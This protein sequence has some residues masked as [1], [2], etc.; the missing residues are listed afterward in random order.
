V[1]SSVF[2]PNVKESHLLNF[3]IMEID[4]PKSVHRKM[5]IEIFLSV[6][7]IGALLI[8][9][10]AGVVKSIGGMIDVLRL[11]LRPTTQTSSKVKN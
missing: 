6:G 8:L 11:V 2:I 7:F 4:I 9:S 10:Y 5:K 1:K 3:Q